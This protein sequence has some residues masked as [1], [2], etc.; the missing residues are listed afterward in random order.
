MS[1][2][3]RQNS[4]NDSFRSNKRSRHI[5]KE[6]ELNEIDIEDHFEEEEGEN[7]EENDSEH[8]E[9]SEASDDEDN[10]KDNDENNK[11]RSPVWEHFIQFTDQEG[12]KWAKCKYCG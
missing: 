1:N 4:N 8:E 6:I 11:K 3:K 9:V 12:V 5:N 10:D 7:I 2:Q